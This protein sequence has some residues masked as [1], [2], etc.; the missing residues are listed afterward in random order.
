MDDQRDEDQEKKIGFRD[1]RPPEISE[2]ERVPLNEANHRIDQICEKNRENEDHEYAAGDI[3]DRKHE[4]E[5]Q[6]R[7]EYADGTAIKECHVPPGW[8][9]LLC[10]ALE[11]LL[12]GRQSPLERRSRFVD[13]DFAH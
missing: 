8:G 7:R 6:S 2:Y 1:M 10:L 4:G 3:E 13:S 5:E 9:G 12:D 11:F